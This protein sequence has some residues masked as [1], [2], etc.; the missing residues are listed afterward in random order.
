MLIQAFIDWAFGVSAHTLRSA[1]RLIE[2]AS[3]DDI[4]EDM[5]ANAA[6]TFECFEA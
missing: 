4:A 3:S 5:I 2:I 6:E 1:K